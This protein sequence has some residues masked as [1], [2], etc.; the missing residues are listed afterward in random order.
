MPA[1]SALAT[2]LKR[3]RERRK[4][5]LRALSKRC[6]LS[7]TTLRNLEAGGNATIGSVALIASALNMTTVELLA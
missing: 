5:S 1:M 3:E 6:G 4:L 7:R 2:N